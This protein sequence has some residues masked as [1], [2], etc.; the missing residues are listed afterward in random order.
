MIHIHV[1]YISFA[2]ICFIRPHLMNMYELS[3][4]FIFRINESFYIRFV[5]KQDALYFIGS[6]VEDR[7]ILIESGSI[8]I[9][10]NWKSIGNQ[11]NCHQLRND[12]SNILDR[13]FGLIVDDKFTT[14]SKYF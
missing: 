1:K 11:H 13:I 2:S 7:N 9:G 14:E 6:K 3:L 10:K 8:R 12:L 4:Y 5:S